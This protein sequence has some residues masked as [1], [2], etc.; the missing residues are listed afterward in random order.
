MHLR[1]FD[2]F[3]G[4]RHDTALA[5]IAQ[6]TAQGDQVVTLGEGT[7]R[8]AIGCFVTIEPESPF[9]D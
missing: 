6:K 8:V 4:Q 1:Q 5:T 2:F 9:T 7:E 3:W